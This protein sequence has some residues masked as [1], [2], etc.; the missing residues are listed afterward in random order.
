MVSIAVQR[1]VELKY[2]HCKLG[3]AIETLQLVLV[4]RIIIDPV[5]RM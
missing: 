3:S 2:M 1:A 4:L 5:Q